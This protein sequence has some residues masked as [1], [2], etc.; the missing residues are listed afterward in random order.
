MATFRTPLQVREGIGGG[1]GLGSMRVLGCGVFLKEG[2]IG[3]VGV[4]NV[5]QGRGF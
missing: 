2:L 5:S 3:I 1:Q 4:R